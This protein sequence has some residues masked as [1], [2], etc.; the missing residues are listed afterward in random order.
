ASTGMINVTR[1]EYSTM[2]WE[3]RVALSKSGIGSAVG[4]SSPETRTSH[5]TNSPDLKLPYG[6]VEIFSTRVILALAPQETCVNAPAAHA[7]TA[8]A[9][10]SRIVLSPISNPSVAAA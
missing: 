3:L 4:D 1:V 10:A 7:T 6:A 9:C 2:P 8:K 5:R